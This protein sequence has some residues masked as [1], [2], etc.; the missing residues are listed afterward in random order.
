MILR[1]LTRKREESLRAWHALDDLLRYRR[2]GR[3]SFP[4]DEEEIDRLAA[5]A[6]RRAARWDALL[7]LWTFGGRR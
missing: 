1:Y 5:R 6:R 2:V 7:D 3:P 4:G